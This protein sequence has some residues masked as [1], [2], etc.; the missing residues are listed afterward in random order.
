LIFCNVEL[1]P[2][3]SNNWLRGDQLLF[4]TY[5]ISRFECSK[6]LVI[7]YSHCIVQYLETQNIFKLSFPLQV[8]QARTTLYWPWCHTQ[9]SIATTNRTLASSRTW[10]PG[11]RPGIIVTSMAGRRLSCART[12]R[13]SAR[14]C[15]CATGGLTCGVTLARSCTTSTSDCTGPHRDQIG[16]TECSPRS[17]STRYSFDRALYR[18]IYI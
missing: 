7:G 15:S 9:T 11:V 17:C 5:N 18:A 13:N 16:L 1:S 12:A 8:N 3:D 4:W 10:T 6:R 2:L 14:Q